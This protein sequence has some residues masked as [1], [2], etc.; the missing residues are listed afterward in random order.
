MRLLPYGDGA[1]YVDLELDDAEGR[2]ARTHAVAARLRESLPS[3]DGVVGAG[4]VVLAGIGGRDDPEA[5]VV[6]AIR[7]PNG[8]SLEGREHRVRVVYDGPDLDAVAAAA[9]LDRARVV[10]LH[11]ARTYVVELVGFLPGFAYL[12]PVDPR[13]VLPRRPS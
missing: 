13:L 2:A 11:A 10:E 12:G 6:E 8:G 1:L 7:A 4:V 9:G 5:L 3:A